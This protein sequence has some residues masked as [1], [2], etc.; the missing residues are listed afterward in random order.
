M[1]DD[2]SGFDDTE[3]P[4]ID[5]EFPLVDLSVFHSDIKSMYT[6]LDKLERP[7]LLIEEEII[8]METKLNYWLK[9]AEVD[10][11]P[12]TMVDNLLEAASTAS[13]L[14]WSIDNETN[15]RPTDFFKDVN[16]LRSILYLLV[17][18]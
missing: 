8:E 9:K 6:Y 5:E 13:S 1:S 4:G 3:T 7:S 12:V 16:A 17:E 11:W 2:D 10:G 18:D 14:A 15:K